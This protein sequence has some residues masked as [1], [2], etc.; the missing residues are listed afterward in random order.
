MS[1]SYRAA[2]HPWSDRPFSL[3]K[4]PPIPSPLE[5]GE[6]EEVRGALQ[7]PSRRGVTHKDLRDRLAPRSAGALAAFQY[8]GRGMCVEH[9]GVGPVLVH[10]AP[11]V[12]PV[13]E[14]LAADQMAA[15]APHVLVA[16]AGQM[17]VTDHHVVDVGRLVGEM[18]EAALVAA[19][20]EE[21]VMVDIPVAAVE[22]I[23][24]A[25][26]VAL[27][28]G[29]E[30]IRAAEAEHLAVPAERLLEVLRHH[31]EMAEPLDV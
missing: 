18:I 8:I 15:D 3:P 14:Q 28:P 10:P 19:N 20:A 4:S 5:E 22:A 31:D 25:N 11:R 7:S 30:F 1:A 12:G 27:L 6:W 16:F 17:L 23:K 21:G 2:R 24:G 13:I 29:I 26:D 9:I